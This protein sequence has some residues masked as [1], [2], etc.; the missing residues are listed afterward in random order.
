MRTLTCN[1]RRNFESEI[2]NNVKQNPKVFWSYVKSRVKTHAGIG[3]VEGIDGQ[4]HHSDCTNKANAF[5]DFLSSVFVDEDPDT[6]P[7]FVTFRDDLPFSSSIQVTPT[8]AFEKLQSLKCD[9]SPGP[10]VWPP[11]ILK[12]LY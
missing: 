6:V 10:D 11:I 7:T 9:K 5:N 12:K 1:L 2:A 4:L 8:I 3:C